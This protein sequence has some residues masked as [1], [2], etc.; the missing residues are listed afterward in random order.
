M[1]AAFL[2]FI[3]LTT[4]AATKK[5]AP[6]RPP[7]PPVPVVIPR[8]V[9]VAHEE[10]A[11]AHGPNVL[12]I[13]VDNLND[14][15][16]FLGGH[17]QAR[18]PNIDRLAH[19]GLSFTNAHCPSLGSNASRTTFLTG[20]NPWNSG[21]WNN[22]QDWRHCIQLVGKPTIPEYFHSA[23]WFTAAAGKIFHASHGGPQGKLTGWQGGR[24]GFEL[25]HAWRARLPSPGVQIPDLAVHAGQ[26]LNGLNLWQLDWGAIDKSEADMDDFKVAASAAQFLGEKRDRPF[27]LAVGFYHPHLPWYAPKKY[28]DMFPVDQIQLPEMKLE[29]LK[30]T[31]DDLKPVMKGD[32][33]LLKQAVQAY[34]AHVAFADEMVGR[35]LDALEHSPH[36]S[37]TVICLTSDHGWC[38]ESMLGVKNGLALEA[39]RV[40]LIISAPGITQ[41]GTQSA[42][43]VSLV[44]L[45]PT[46]CDL[47]GAAKP[48]HLDG[49][50]LLPLLKNPSAVRTSPAVT[51]LGSD[52]QARY[53]VANIRWRL[54][55]QADGSQELYDHSKDP[56]ERKNLLVGNIKDA[57]IVAS[58][59]QQSMP[60][61]WRSA[62]RQIADVKTD[63]STDG[64]KTFWFAAGDRFNAADSPD[65]TARNLDIE[66]EFNFN[67]ATDG[68]ASLLSHGDTKLGWAIHFVGGRPAITVNYDG[69]SSTLK[70][71]EVLPAGR[72]TLR[73]LMGLDGTLALS[74]TGLQREL[75]GYMPMEGGFPRKPENG[76]EIAHSFGPLDPKKFPDSAPFDSLILQVRLSLLPAEPPKERTETR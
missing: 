7:A 20:V 38:L 6:V 65:I 27:F 23:G 34:L 5:R 52:D 41:P 70:S 11:P 66:A 12:F 42:Q 1:T 2:L 13:L 30:E 16:G 51:S 3:P 15:C 50:S 45:Y 22:E 44:D 37:K 26:N 49:E 75:R 40:P 39:T 57:D 24:R 32:K 4:I 46:L 17:P 10:P 67:P 36:N 28:F 63:A 73:A 9:P 14:W 48:Q 62:Y 21:I 35:V 72:I 18:T 71:D 53:A 76:F 69:L 43:P 58:E 55:R 61:Q 31:P 74:A 8:A 54:L 25:D 68:D 19:S 60:K 47:A 56:L 33:K 29:A 64:G 59:L